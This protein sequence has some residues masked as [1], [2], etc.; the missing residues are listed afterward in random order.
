MSTTDQLSL[1]G[2]IGWIRSNAHRVNRERIL[3]RIF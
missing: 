3:K 1:M 2:G